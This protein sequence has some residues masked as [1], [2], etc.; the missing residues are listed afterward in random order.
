MKIDLSKIFDELF[1]INRSLL[2]E[3][4][5]KS[6]KILNRYINIKKLKYKSGSQ[7]FDWK[8]PNEW[9]VKDAYI[10]FKKKRILDYKNSNLHIIN[11]SY[12]INKKLNLKNLKKILHTIPNKPKY[13]PYITSYYKKNIGFCSSDN[14]KKR[15]KKGFY[16]CVIKTKFKSGYLVN[17]LSEIKGKSKKTN[18]IS[19]YL[20]HPSLANNELSG[21]LV[22]IGLY[23]RIQDWKEKNFTYKFL[24]N[25]ET[26]GSLCFLKSHGRYLK[27]NLNSGLVLTCLGGKKNYLSYK[28]SKNE[29]SNLDRL[30]KLFKEKKIKLREYDPS[31]GSDERQYNSPGFDL[32]VGNIIRDGY[33]DY[34]GYHNSGDNKKY[35]NIKKIEDSINIIEGVYKNLDLTLPIKRFMPYGE[36]M[37]GKRNLY[38]TT[39]SDKTRNKSS[40]NSMGSREELNILLTIL[41]YSDGKK[42]ILDIIE[43]KRLNP[44]KS[45]YILK[46]S[47]KMKLLYFLNS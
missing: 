29:N 9:V 15:L 27:K 11:Y 38:P 3:G 22:M 19:T 17:G 41:G 18:L 34:A 36:L 37:L 21:P 24:I 2:G 40:D 39:N 6:L 28:L 7:I 43:L 30:L 46:K 4:Y 23:N 13:I 26:I 12:S 44:S 1:P 45:F 42:N 31:E 32:P 33:M 25:P 35:M 16:D 5:D 47:L 8:V 14:F 20:C 10:K